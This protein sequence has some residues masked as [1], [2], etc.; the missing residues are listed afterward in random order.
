M[1]RT[2]AVGVGEAA[3]RP[4][5]PQSRLGPPPGNLIPLVTRM[6]AAFIYLVYICILI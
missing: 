6:W 4:Y 2:W 3:M 5:P 1:D